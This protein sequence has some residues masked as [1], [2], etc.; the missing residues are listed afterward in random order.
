M[1]LEILH[2]PGGTGKTAM[3]LE[4]ARLRAA[5]PSASTWMVV[6]DQSTFIMEKRVLETLGDRDGNRIRVFSLNR[7]AWH[8]IANTGGSPRPFLDASGKGVLVYRIMREYQD[9]LPL[10][11]DTIRRGGF[12]KVAGDLMAE[13]KRYGVTPEGLHRVASE[14]PDPRLAIKLQELA[15]IGDAY[16]AAMDGHG[17]LDGEDR[18]KM[19]AQRLS[20][21]PDI[22]AIHVCLDQFLRFSPVQIKLIQT[23]MVHAASVSVSL[24]MD[25]PEGQD[26]PGQGRTGQQHS[27]RSSRLAAAALKQFA[28]E[29]DIP[30]VLTSA[31][32]RDWRHAPGSG[33]AFLARNLSPTGTGIYG[34]SPTDIRMVAH[35]DPAA[36]IHACARRI[37]GLCRDGGCRFRDLAVLVPDSAEYAAI[38]RRVFHL[39][40]IPFFM[41]RKESLAGNPVAVALLAPFDILR[42]GWRHD[43]AFRLLKTGLLPV[44]QAATDR[45]ENH[46]LATGLRGRRLWCEHPLEDGEMEEVRV[47]LTIPLQAFRERVRGQVPVRMALEAYLGML[48]AWRL[49][50]MIASRAK[51]L[52]ASGNLAV[53]GHMR[54][55]WQSACDLMDQ[56]LELS[57]EGTLTL[58]ELHGMLQTGLEGGTTGIIPPSLDEVF[59]GTPSR[60]Q[61]SQARH[62]FVTGMAEGW[63]P[64]ASGGQELLTDADRR[65]MALHGLELA[66]DTRAMS[67][68][69]REEL[70]AVITT[71]TEGLWLSRPISD[72]EGKALQPSPVF[73]EV[74]DKFPQLQEG[75]A[76]DADGTAE[77][78]YP[79]TLLATTP[80]A[81][82]EVLVPWL[83][84][85]GTGNQSGSLDGTPPCPADLSGSSDKKPPG[86]STGPSPLFVELFNSC[87][88]QPG[89]K[90]HWQRVADGLQWRNSAVLSPGWFRERYGAMLTGSIS[91]METYRR[92]PFSWFARNAALLR[93]RQACGLRDVG[94]GLLMHEVIEAVFSGVEMDGGWD[95]FDTASLPALIGDAV[96]QGAA[97]GTGISPLHPGLASWFSDRLAKAALMAAGRIVRQIQ[98]GTFRPFGHELGFGDQG[99]FPPFVVPL[100]NGGSMRLQGRL[101]RLDLHEAPDGLYVRVVDYKS[102]DRPL[103]LSDVM[104][105]LS[106]QLPAYL[107]VALASLRE[108]SLQAGGRPVMPAGI[109]HMRLEP[110]DIRTSDG[111]AS[112]AD[113]ERNRRMR[114]SGY[115][116]DDPAILTAMDHQIEGTGSSE[117]VKA[118]LNRDG[119]VA[120][121]TR[122]LSRQG[123]ERMGTLLG[124]LLGKMGERLISGDIAISPVRAGSEKACDYCPYGRVCRFE[125]GVGNAGWNRLSVTAEADV[126]R[127]LN[128]TGNGADDRLM[129]DEAGNGVR[130]EVDG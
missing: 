26:F 45:L 130:H 113:A 98:A 36:E 34:G 7:L 85:G 57:G 30:V 83:R 4:A 72:T 33:L 29:N 1:Q 81:F 74:R 86:A 6:P 99:I 108:R 77:P 84:D 70:D 12:A 114:L 102:G 41:D 82:L 38:V 97:H 15:V 8:L 17:Y 73:T 39:H 27:G 104:N 95:S 42:G 3:L 35:P 88:R 25:S 117:V 110:P 96:R 31:S 19:A 119:T 65:T 44:R 91:S 120:G 18:L 63:I 68:E 55:I 128:G 125:P 48:M 46:A 16:E 105:G 89:M 69:R 111:S 37:V 23:L 116:L 51:T 124:V 28:A 93:E 79:E 5:D 107:A 127:M 118:S 106:L 59:V 87:G 32:G 122:T 129:T 10:F 14:V 121:R 20:R 126:R 58:T 94:F 11:S 61:V 9:R 76:P 80:R 13:F 60:S 47:L 24:R 49:P 21:M 52:E 101:D 56:I 100:P 67:R 43:D 2:G 109:F 75:W 115:V 62:L 53:A 40:H 22:S 90:I 112:G 103:A 64:A 54:Q 92:C 50:Q 123:F 71:P 78:W 66:P